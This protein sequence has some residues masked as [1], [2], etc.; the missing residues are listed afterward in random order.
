MRTFYRILMV[1]PLIIF[2]GCAIKSRPLKPVEAPVSKLQQ[3]EAQRAAELSPLKGYKRKI[4]IGRFSNETNYG[5]VL[6][7]DENDDRIGK[8]AS[9]MLS[10]RL[11]KSNRFIV[12]ERP[13]LHVLKDEAAFIKNTN[14]IGADAI[15]VGSVTEF[16]RAVTGK[17]GFLSST[18]MQTAKARVE[19]RLVDARTGHAFFSAIGAGE[20]STETGDMAG[21][22]S[23]ADYDATLNDRAI[24][25]AISDVI[26][27]LI[28][29]LESRPWQTDVLDIQ[30]NQ[31]FI[32]G[33]KSQGVKEGDSLIVFQKT[34]TINSQQSGFA[35]D[36]PPKRIGMIKVVSLFGD[37]ETNEGAVGA[38]IEGAMDISIKDQLFIREGEK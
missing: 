32:S 37:N 19:I 8:Q 22:G 5:K 16:G 26:D 12:F 29:T 20:S 7:T 24:A 34:K 38:I 36:L 23:Q 10:S 9:D 6:L 1:M 31:V 28:S 33:G 30:G 27:K 13:D 4:V 17:T 2:T 14:I 21:F 35:I 11:I 18:K 15:I 25:S 3:V